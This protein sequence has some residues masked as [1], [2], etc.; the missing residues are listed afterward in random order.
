MTDVS[1]LVSSLLPSIGSAAFGGAIGGALGWVAKKIAKVVAVL[2]TVFIIA[3]LG[4]LSYK[5]IIT[6]NWIALYAL[7]ASTATWAIQATSG[8][9]ESVAVAA[10]GLGSFVTCFAIA[11][12]RA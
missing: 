2:A 11:F 5:G 12:Q 7:L 1:S 4:Y 6:V 8:L 9:V 10:P 3:P